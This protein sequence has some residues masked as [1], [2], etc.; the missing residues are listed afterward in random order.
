MLCATCRQE[1]KAEA[2]AEDIL[3]PPVM[4]CHLCTPSSE[5]VHTVLYV[6]VFV[7]KIGHAVGHAIQVI[8][9][10]HNH[11][12]TPYKSTRWSERHAAMR[13]EHQI[14]QSTGNTGLLWGTWK[15]CTVVSMFLFIHIN[16]FNRGI[17]ILSMLLGTSTTVL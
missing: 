3:H 15:F 1:A 6:T 9:N 13:C 8:F 5:C 17:L 11:T 14:W 10:R 2:A 12:W 4:L 7:K 16:H